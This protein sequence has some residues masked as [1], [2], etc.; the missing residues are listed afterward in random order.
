MIYFYFVIVRSPQKSIPAYQTP[1][2]MKEPV[3]DSA[4]VNTNAH[5]PRLLLE[6]SVQVRTSIFEIKIIQ[7]CFFRG[8]NCFLFQKRHEKREVE[9]IF[10][11]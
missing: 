9:A 2:R 3:M 11:D 1:V 4:M 7:L 10:K 5:V 8:I 6:H